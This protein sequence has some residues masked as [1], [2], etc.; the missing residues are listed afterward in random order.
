MVRGS[1]F[2]GEFNFE[3]FFT[4]SLIFPLF[5]PLVGFAT[6]PS[7]RWHSSSFLWLLGLLAMF[8]VS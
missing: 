6:S 5:V 4:L 8:H 2:Q 1:L 7:S 3:L